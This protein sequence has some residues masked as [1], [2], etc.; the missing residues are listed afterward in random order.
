MQQTSRITRV[1]RTRIAT[2]DGALS[3]LSRWLKSERWDQERI[4]ILVDANTRIH[5]LPP[6]LEKVPVLKSA[7]VLEIQSGEAFKSMAT[8]EVLWNELLNQGADRNALLI[9]LG[10]GVVSDLGGFVASGF[11][12]GIAYLNLPTTLIGQAD[13]AI[14]GKTGVNLGF[15]KNQIGAFYLPAAIFLFPQFLETLPPEHLRSG[16]AEVVKCAL[17]GD[18]V[19][20]RR[21]EKVGANEILHMPISSPFWREM[22]EKAVRIKLKIVRD[23]FLEQRQRKKLNFG[24]TI[25]HALESFVNERGNG[26]LLHGDAVVVGMIAE[27][28][29][30][31]KRCGL[32]GED[33]K[34]MELFL[35]ATYQ[36]D[37]FTARDIPAL[38]ERMR[39]DKKNGGGRIRFSLIRMVGLPVINVVCS[40][41]EIAEALQFV[42]NG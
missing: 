13:A 18:E 19:L 29:L 5:C 36:T 24:H 22:V 34:K 38:I 39:H 41:V 16:F 37:L 12:R 11:K 14:G 25:G 1:H 28:Y 17:V 23:D 27:G 15:L 26:G 2:G 32:P 21:I 35:R 40:D 42:S 30:S 8:A 20:W 31:Q 10:G 6:L 7:R 9:N 4:F 3:Q 33:F